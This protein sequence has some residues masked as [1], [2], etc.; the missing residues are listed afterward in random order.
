MLKSSVHGGGRGQG[1]LFTRTLIFQ[2]FEQKRLFQKGVYMRT[3]KKV[4]ILLE[5]GINQQFLA[6]YLEISKATMSRIKN[7]GLNLTKKGS[8]KLDIFIENL[9]NILRGLE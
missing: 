7:D 6:D 5:N 1:V 3:S 4:Q 2:S 8:E 9:Q